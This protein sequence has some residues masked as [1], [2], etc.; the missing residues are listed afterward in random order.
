MPGKTVSLLYNYIQKY[1]V[2]T[3]FNNL[4]QGCPHL[5]QAEA[6]GEGGGVEEEGGGAGQEDRLTGEI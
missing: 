1:L 2:F 4:L 6:G 3:T 5:G